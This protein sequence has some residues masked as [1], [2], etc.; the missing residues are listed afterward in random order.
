MSAIPKYRELNNLS[1]EDLIE[2]YNEAA[3]HTVV[4]TGFYLDELVRRDNVR[5]SKRMLRVSEISLIV[6]FI[7]L[8]VAMIAIFIK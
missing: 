4:G 3:E 5:E 8:V 2:K 1:D 7:S 6:A